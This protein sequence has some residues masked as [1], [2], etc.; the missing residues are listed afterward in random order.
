[1][2]TGLDA[3]R[4]EKGRNPDDESWF[5]FGEREKERKERMARLNKEITEHQ[6]AGKK[7]DQ[8]RCQG[9]ADKGGADAAAIRRP[10]FSSP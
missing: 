8:A 4:W 2:T 10:L 7:L 1:L 9:A 6:K 3:D 5:A